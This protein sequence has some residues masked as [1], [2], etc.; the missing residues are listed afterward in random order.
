MKTIKVLVPDPVL[1]AIDEKRGLVPLSAYVRSVL[2]DHIYDPVVPQID[3]DK[4]PTAHRH[5]FKRDPEPSRQ[6]RG[7]KFYTARCMCGETKE[8][9][10]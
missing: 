9:T 5:V 1:D 4:V 7:A 6:F 8:T 10:D 2:E 3:P